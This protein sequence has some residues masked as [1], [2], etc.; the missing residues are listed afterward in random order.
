MVHGYLAEMG[1]TQSWIGIEVWRFLS[2]SEWSWSAF[3]VNLLE[4]NWSRS[5]VSN[6]EIETKNTAR[7]KCD[8]DVTII[9]PNFENFGV[10][11]Q[12]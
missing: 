5:F 9:F 7:V 10:G 8:F 1:K 11:V 6:Y 4:S 12:Y 3:F 2:V